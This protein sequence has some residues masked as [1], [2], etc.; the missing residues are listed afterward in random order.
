MESIHALLVLCD[1]NPSVSSANPPQK[2]TN[3]EL[4]YFRCQLEQVI[5]QTVELLVIRPSCDGT[6]VASEISRI[7][8]CR[9]CHVRLIE[10]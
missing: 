8:D 10:L 9:E 3:A 6:A 4:Y 1:G 2:V 7:K 5:Q